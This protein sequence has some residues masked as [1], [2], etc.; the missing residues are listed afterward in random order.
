MD[1]VRIMLFAALAFVLLLIWQA[2]ERDYGTAATT[3][4]PAMATTEAPAS[5]PQPAATPTTPEAAPEVPTATAA[6]HKTTGTAPTEAVSVRTDT[7]D[8]K[9]SLTGGDVVQ[10]LLPD[11]PVSL[12]KRD[13][14]FVLLDQSPKLT[15]VAQ[16]GLIG[17]P[18][19][20]NHRDQYVADAMRYAMAPGASELAVPLHWHSPD[21]IDVIKTFLFHR[22]SHVID[23]RYEI[24]NH[25]AVPW[26]GRWYGQLQRKYEKESQGIGHT[27]TYTG[28]AVSSPKKRYEKLP[29]D[30]M[31]EDPLKRNIKDGWVAILQ[32]YFV[33]AII[34][35]P[36]Q[37]DHYYT[38]VV[39]KD[40][41][42]IGTM[43][44]EQTVA[45]GATETMH[46]RIYAGPKVQD[47]LAKIAPGLELTV[48][49]GALWFIAKPLFW[50][51]EHIHG[52]T[53]NWGWSIILL[54]ML[55]KALF[56]RL[57]AA[58]YR[59][60]AKMRAVQPRLVAMKERYAGDK[61]KLN[62]AMMEMY[63]QEKINPLGGCL[64][65]VIQI[66]VFLSLYW[67]LLESVELR[68]APFIF[69]IK[70]LTSPDPYYVLPVLMG[71]TMFVQQKLNPSAMDPMQQ[72]VMQVLPLVFGVFFAFFQSGLVL[73]WFV[74]NLLSIGQQ[75]LIIRGLE[76]ERAKPANA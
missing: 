71:I 27:H 70:D 60:M 47:K 65:V 58:S 49:Y 11:Y 74:N 22:G 7:L 6:P 10:A 30:K 62:Q 44:P 51:L 36:S 34:P 26:K 61:T 57:S 64:P 37:T 59:S 32:H 1:N 40:H 20:P 48:D 68:Q 5:A 3:A 41:Y 25:G 63:K 18:A 33:A 53:G 24:A 13:Q 54:T 50:L 43:G 29:F 15:F 16:G 17:A 72:K 12:K 52:V 56:Y 23:V 2:W 66:P 55:V 4:A 69:W 67:V 9:I 46:Y 19:A 39:D 35:D 28:A 45:P 31:G 42:I 8:V 75:W 76:R 38:K 14:P 73:Y 21:G